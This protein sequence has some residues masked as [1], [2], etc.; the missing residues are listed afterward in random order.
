[1]NPLIAAALAELESKGLS[2]ALEAVTLF[3]QDLASGKSIGDSLQ[4]LEMRAAEK[5]A[6]ALR[7]LL[8]PKV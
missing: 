6:T 1:M 3:V 2:L 4:D 5:Q 7:D 8:A